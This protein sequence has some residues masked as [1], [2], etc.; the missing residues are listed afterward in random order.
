VTTLKEQQRLALEILESLKRVR[1]LIDKLDRD[2]G[3]ED[4]IQELAW[5]V[6][7][8]VP[9]AQRNL[10]YLNDLPPETEDLS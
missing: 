5:C 2:R 3:L 4:A 8:A 6:N 9:I 7:S 10:W 1:G